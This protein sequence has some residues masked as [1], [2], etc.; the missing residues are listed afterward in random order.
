MPTI[1]VGRIAAGHARPDD[2]WSDNTATSSLQFRS[3]SSSQSDS[4]DM[5]AGSESDPSPHKNRLGKWLGVQCTELGP[6]GAMQ[7]YNLL[8]DASC[9]D[10]NSLDCGV[11]RSKTSFTL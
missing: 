6:E 11:V 7:A 8:F 10:T 1:L 5:S 4:L 2:S 3:Y 9:R